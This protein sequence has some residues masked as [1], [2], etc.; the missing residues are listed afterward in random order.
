MPAGCEDQGGAGR[1]AGQGGV[2][3]G[4]PGVKKSAT[5]NSQLCRKQSYAHVGRYRFPTLHFRTL[6]YNN[7][8][9]VRDQI[10]E[11]E[12]PQTLYLT[13]IFPAEV[14]LL[15]PTAATSERCTT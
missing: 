4:S 1:G 11:S 2:A 7:G 6:L 15:L 12:F 8:Q 14:S 10:R 5:E 9:S 3:R 13:C